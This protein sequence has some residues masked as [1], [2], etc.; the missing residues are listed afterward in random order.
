M[1]L[2][3][4]AF[5]TDHALSYKHPV[6]LVHF[7]GETKDYATAKVAS[8]TNT[9]EPYIVS[10]SGLAHKVTPEEGESSISG[11]K[12]N[13]L[14]KND[15]ITALFTTD[16]YYFHR[17]KVTIK[18]GYKGMT[19]ANMLTVMT[20]WVTGYRMTSDGLAYEFDITDP[21]KWMQR[22][23]F[24]NASE[25]TPLV[26]SGNPLTILLQ[27]LTSGDGDNGDYDLLAAAN[28]LDIDE[29][30]I[31]VAGIEAARDTWYP[32]NSNYMRWTIVKRE[33]AKN[34][35]EREIL[36]VLNIYPVVDGQG[37]FSVK[38]FK[39]A[40]AALDKVQAFDESNIIGLPTW[41]GNL[42]DMINEVEIFYDYDSS[43]G[44]YDIEE[45][46]IDS[47]SVDNRGPGRKPLNI[48]SRGIHTSLS[49][50]S[51]P[52][53][54]DDIINRRAGDIIPFTHANIPNIET[55]TRG[56]SN[57]RMELVSR[58]VDWNKGLVKLNLLDTNFDRRNYAVISP[59]APLST[60]TASTSVTMS[61]GNVIKWNTSD[62]VDIKDAR[63]R[64]KSTSLTIKTRT[65][66][67]GVIELNNT[68]TA[69]AAGIASSWIMT[70]SGFTHVTTAQQLYGYICM[71]SSTQFS[72]G[73]A[74]HIL[75]P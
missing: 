30:Y 36:K 15:E 52:S 24:R 47:D 74:A 40:I 25:T 28:G 12:V 60:C 16:T 39:P 9:V 18:A 53:R 31:D 42:K 67:T 56:F 66:N 26:L 8:P 57:T 23:I 69:L 7:D 37:R 32:G 29:S 10:I 50:R 49:P 33:K 68:S 61:T 1:R 41:D 13:I 46:F 71:T 59:S 51:L 43:G 63:G 20:G 27:I 3:N 35:I 48:K 17:K 21:I 14:D 65:T 44:T 64:I 34:W 58:S 73:S 6:Y 55:G 11:I 19:E 62:V 75:V 45:Y 70:Y 54:A 22:K 72:D 4:T 5:D 2:T 38:P